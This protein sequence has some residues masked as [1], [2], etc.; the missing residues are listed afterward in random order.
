[1]TTN[2]NYVATLNRGVAGYYTAQDAG[3]FNQRSATGSFAAFCAFI[4]KGSYQQLVPPLTATPAQWLWG[5]LDTVNH[6]GWGLS[7]NNTINGPGL[8]AQVYDNT[9]V[10]AT[11]SIAPMGNLFERLTLLGLWFDGTNVMLSVNGAI[12]AAAIQSSPGYRSSAL[13]VRLLADPVG[14]AT[15]SEFVD[16]ISAG[17]SPVDLGGAAGTAVG[18]TGRLVGTSFV[19]FCEGLGGGAFL[20]QD[21]GIDW[22]HRYTP[23]AVAGGLTATV[24]K[25]AAGSFVTSPVPAPASLPDVGNSG[26]VLSGP[27]APVALLRSGAPT[28]VGRKNTSVFFTAPS[29][30]PGS[31][32]PIPGGTVVDFYVSSALGND[33]NPGTLAAPFATLDRAEQLI[34]DPVQLTYQIGRAHV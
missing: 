13:P 5:N 17:Y 25:A 4:L 32:T 30:T 12:V 34:A 33:N 14:A 11:A 24:T 16:V 19:A 21:A 1:M 8:L 18:T 10:I 28:I 3:A 26:P 9:G 7:I 15:S 2:A 20:D 6:R 29:A 23:E 22:L 27:G 31:P